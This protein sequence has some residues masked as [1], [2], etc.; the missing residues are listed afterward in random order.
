MVSAIVIGAGAAGLAASS[1]LTSAGYDVTILEARERVGGRAHTGSINGIPIDLGPMWIHGVANNPLY[2]IA[3]EHGLAM[4]PTN[5]ENST[6]YNH[7]GH[8]IATDS[9]EAVWDDFEAVMERVAHYQDS[10]AS[11]QSLEWGIEQAVADLS[12]SVL[13]DGSEYAQRML[14]FA[15]ADDVELEYAGKTSDLDLWWFDSDGELDGGDVLLPGGYVELMEAIST[16]LTITYNST[17]TRIEYGKRGVTVTATEPAADGDEVVYSADYLVVTVPVGVL[18]A[19]PAP[20]TFDP[21]MPSAWSTALSHRGVGLLDKYVFAF[22][23]SFFADTHFLYHVDSTTKGRYSEW[24]NGN[25]YLNGSKASQSGD[26]AAASD[27]TGANVLAAFNAAAFAAEIGDNATDAE[28]MAAAV[29][30]LSGMYPDVDVASEIIDFVR[31]DWGNDPL[32]Q[33]SYSFNGL[34]SRPG[35]DFVNLRGEELF[36]GRMLFAGEHTHCR[37]FGTVHGAYMSGNDAADCIIKGSCPKS[38]YDADAETFLTNKAIVAITLGGVAAMLLICLVGSW[39]RDGRPRYL[40]ELYGPGSRR[41]DRVSLRTPGAAGSSGPA[42]AE[43]TPSSSVPHFGTER[44]R[45]LSGAEEDT[46][47]LDAFE[48]GEVFN[49]ITGLQQ[50]EQVRATSSNLEMARYPS[51]A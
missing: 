45:T 26:D 21:P 46:G 28:V 36:N 5:Y 37:Y 9:M 1:R 48:S 29:E 41:A 40:W 24:L 6:Y 13:G 3:E 2:E 23:S 33:G 49:T 15:V 8:E 50:P 43:G 47:E 25:T 34:G 27:G 12:L 11:R 17:V 14:D 44:E 32:A 19:S 10:T 4:V 20:I 22:K 7:T 30:I 18:R 16:D 35:R 51:P 39:V 42:F 38:C 31:T